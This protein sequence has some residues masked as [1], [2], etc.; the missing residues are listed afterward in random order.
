M[1]NKMAWLNHNTERDNTEIAK[2]R[3]NF[4]HFIWFQKV[5]K[6]AAASAVKR[7]TELSPTRGSPANL[8]ADEVLGGVDAVVGVVL[9]LVGPHLLQLRNVGVV[10]G[11]RVEDQST[12]GAPAWGG[13]GLEHGRKS[14]HRAFCLTVKFSPKARFQTLRKKPVKC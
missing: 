4:R 3:R 2:Q 13:G 10:L 6:D 14:V 9:D 11:V 12:G 8:L 7:T 1:R 5:L